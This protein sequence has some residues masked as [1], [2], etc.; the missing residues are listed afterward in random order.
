[1][2]IEEL[3]KERRN[4]QDRIRQF[5]SKEIVEFAN[6]SG[7]GVCSVDVRILDIT[8]VSDRFPK[9]DVGGVSVQ[10]DL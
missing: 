7:V 9:Y 2:T 4:L 8:N 6:K 10:L 5:L 1:M 3:V